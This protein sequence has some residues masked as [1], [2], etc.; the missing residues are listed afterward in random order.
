MLGDQ[1]ANI[2]IE[3][4][5][6]RPLQHRRIVK[7]E[8][9]LLGREQRGGAI[10]LALDYPKPPPGQCDGLAPAIGGAAEQQRV[11]ET[12]DSKPDAPLRLRLFILLPQ[13]V[14]RDID[15]I[16]E[17]PHG[18]ARELAQLRLIEFSA[19][20]RPVDEPREVDRAKQAGSIWRQ[21]LLAARVARADALAVRKIVLLV[22]AIDEDHSGLGDVVGGAHEPLPQFA[23]T[24]RTH[25]FATEDER[26]LGVGSER[27]HEGI[28]DQHRQVEV[29]ESR[30]IAL[31][32]DERLDIRMIDPQASHHRSTALPGRVDGP[33]HRIPAIH[34]GQ[35]PGCFGSD[36]EDGAAALPDRRKIHSDSAA[37][38]H[39]DRGL[40]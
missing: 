23:G 40:P 2:L 16:V 36:S 10:G 13:R 30:G 20:E 33:A 14:A 26:P 6:V 34:E 27:R 3:A 11:R 18:G 19:L 28:G 35:R 37:L 38:L 31:R 8:R 25:R 22:D 24:H 4:G 1:R 39:G 15:H 12:G 21:H 5:K 9:T 29:A 17:H 7:C 32:I